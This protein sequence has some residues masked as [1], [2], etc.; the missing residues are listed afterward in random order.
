[1]LRAAFLFLLYSSFLTS[2]AVIEV[3]IKGKVKSIREAVK[4][5]SDGDTI[6][7]N[8]G[9]YA[10]SDIIITKRIVLTGINY[11][12]VDA[13]NKKSIF[14]IR[15]PK[16]VISGFKLRNT[17]VSY[18]VEYSAVRIEDSDS[19]V[20]VNNDFY[21]NFFGVYLLGSN[22]CQVNNNKFISFGKSEAGSGNGVHLWKCNNISINNNRIEGHRDG[23]Y[24]EFARDCYVSGN[25]S[26]NNRRYGM[27]F[28][29]SN[30]C[31]YKNN[32]FTHNS[33]GVAVMYTRYVTM[34]ENKFLDNWGT[35]SYGLLLKE[36][37]ESEIEKNLFRNNSVGLYSEGSNKIT[38]RNN[39]FTRNGWAVRIMANSMDN[40][41]RNND[42]LLNTF[43]VST[44]SSQNF[45]TFEN[46]YWSQYKG[47]DLNKDGRGDIPHHPVT[48]YSI[49]IEKNS[50]ALLLLRSFLIEIL[51]FSEK[52][53]PILTP[54][55]L[56]D[57][58]PS[59]VR[60]N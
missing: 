40:V 55:K 23:I 13:E 11:P 34:T 37:Y 42:F 9:R 36:I 48:L 6:T 27:H 4:Q 32:T 22:H 47:Y 49:L 59:M 45:N 33:A 7:V 12:V 20:I 50:T 39:T 15:S 60:I 10:E 30:N 53:F 5:A 54:E 51:N 1:M 57:N 58:S 25:Y 41:F 44:N 19:C 18:T 43:E 3:S 8:E 26:T 46:N 52:I 24:L 14:V 28:M 38:I 29:F 56:A 17:P 16:V 31:T 35:G 21:N 2:A